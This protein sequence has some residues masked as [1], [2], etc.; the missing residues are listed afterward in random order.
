M[1]EALR[2]ALDLIR[3]LAIQ[4]N[5]S[6]SPEVAI[7]CAR[8]VHA[9]R[10][11]LK[12]VLLNLLSNAVKFNR[13]GGSVVLSCEET[14][15]HKL[16]IEVT[17]TGPGIAAERLDWLFK[18]F[19]RLGADL[20]GIEGTGLGLALSKRLV[21]AMGGSIGVDSTV[22]A[23]SRFYI[24]LCLLEDP[25]ETLAKDEPAIRALQETDGVPE[26]SGTVLYIED[27][28]SNLRLMEQILSHRSGVKLL[29]AM[30]GQLG[31]DLAHVHTPDWILLD[32]HLPDLPGE[33]V[34]RRLRA[35]PRTQAIPVTV[36]SADAT[37]GQIDRL[38]AAG[39]QDY[40]TKPV[41]V[42]KLLRLLERTMRRGESRSHE[43]AGSNGQRN[44]T[45]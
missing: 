21:E 25:T 16:R 27:N 13:S 7:R 29:S 33:E 19:E 12:Q 2:D 8:H 26:S 41:D 37:P 32:L 44:H 31:L 1:R 17:D 15:E 43:M 39:A 3:P 30:Q 20:S 40:L 36:I 34:L 38:T 28:L 24:E 23:G 14:P 35:D 4:R 9:D 18:P 11:R 5:V 45:E 6:I 42:R 22:G 10:Q